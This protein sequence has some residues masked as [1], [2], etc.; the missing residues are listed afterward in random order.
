MTPLVDLVV[1]GAGGGLVAACIAADAGARVLVVEANPNFSTSNNTAMSTAMI[2]AAGTRWQ[3]ALGVED[4]PERFVSDIRAKT[5][6]SADLALAWALARV[7]VHLVNWLAESA[8]LSVELVTDFEYPGHSRPRCH[9]IPGRS[10]QFILDRLREMTRDRSNIDLIVPARLDRVHTDSS[11][12]VAGVSLRYPDD[13]YEDVD[14]RAVLLATSGFGADA[15]LVARYIPEVAA[16]IYHG[17][18][19]ARGDALR[20]GASMGCATGFLDAYQGHAALAIPQAT[21]VGW[22]TVMHGAVLVNR[23][24]RRFGDETLGYSEYAAKVLAQPDAV[25]YL[26]LDERIDAACRSFDD[27]RRSTEAGA[28]RAAP[29]IEALAAVC[30]VDLNGLVETLA[31]ARRSALGG[32][33]D[34]FGR[35]RWEAPLEPPYLAARV[36]AALFHTQGGL[37][38]DAH[39]RVLRTTGQPLPGLFAS[40]GAAMGISGHGAAGYLAGNGLLAALGLAFI[41]AATVTET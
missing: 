27:Y 1:A 5:G 30:E 41:A 29:T 10:G 35:V 7:S 18:P 31:S 8:K 4:S 12:C 36:G 34:E 16:A 23:R 25:A 11:G 26:V 3:N 24:G 14:S 33:I 20:I 37:C 9:T 6:D 40:G 17:S 13:T 21:L 38:V 32:E 28:L 19:E 39:S 15:E 2:P 22:A